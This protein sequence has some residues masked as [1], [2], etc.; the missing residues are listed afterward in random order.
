MRNS[1]IHSPFGRKNQLIL[2]K[3][4]LIR[5]EHTGLIFMH[6]T[7]LIQDGVSSLGFI[8]SAHYL[9]RVGLFELFL[10]SGIL[11]IN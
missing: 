1:S 4:V 9:N 8:Y 5:P 3:Y 11:G 7:K 2:V 10:E 6:K